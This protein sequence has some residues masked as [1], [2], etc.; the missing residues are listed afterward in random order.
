MINSSIAPECCHIRANW[1]LS[2]DN[3][4][5]TTCCAN[6]SPPCAW[7]D[8]KWNV[9]SARGKSFWEIFLLHPLESTPTLKTKKFTTRNLFSLHK[10]RSRLLRNHAFQKNIQI[11]LEFYITALRQKIKLLISTSR[12]R[13][14]SRCLSHA[15]ECRENSSTNFTDVN[16]FEVVNSFRW[17]SVSCLIENSYAP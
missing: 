14:A 10:T 17:C 4:I 2:S 9:S 1:R 3:E 5:I 6:S 15:S 13:I 11:L 16:M 8:A 12:L 7:V